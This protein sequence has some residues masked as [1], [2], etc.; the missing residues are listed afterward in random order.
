MS[1][2]THTY[3]DVPIKNY[4]FEQFF[5]TFGCSKL[6]ISKFWLMN[7]GFVNGERRYAHIIL[8][9]CQIRPFFGPH[10]VSTF[11]T[12][13]SEVQEMKTF[14][15]HSLTFLRRN[16]FAFEDRLSFERS[17]YLI[18]YQDGQL[19]IRLKSI[20]A[21]LLLPYGSPNG[22]IRPIQMESEETQECKEKECTEKMKMLLNHHLQCMISYLNREMQC[23]SEQSIAYLEKY[24]IEY[25]AELKNKLL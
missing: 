19:L 9:A 2:V 23:S 13:E 17:T 15:V 4:T 3:S 18:P 16:L 24:N 14:W 11:Y 5:E 8:R 6:D 20:R 12:T 25:F 22:E 1:I 21:F 7:V 10:L